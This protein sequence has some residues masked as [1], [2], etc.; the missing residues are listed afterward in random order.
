[1]PIV[2]IS[3]KQAYETLESHLNEKEL[4]NL[5][6]YLKLHIKMEEGK[7]Q[8]KRTKGT[9][10]GRGRTERVDLTAA[11]THPS[12]LLDPETMKMF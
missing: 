10:T 8:S 5:R 7:K 9:L 2:N 11:Q 3:E 6:R 1:M 12:S 4:K